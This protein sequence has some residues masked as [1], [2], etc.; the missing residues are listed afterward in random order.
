MVQ[1]AKSLKEK[2]FLV[3]NKIENS[4]GKVTRAVVRE[5]TGGSDRDVSRYIAEWRKSLVPE[6]VPENVPNHT[7]DNQALTVR[8]DGKVEASTNSRTNVDTQQSGY[9]GTPNSDLEAI[10]RRGAERAAALL[11][12][13][14]A[15]MYHLLENPDRLPED[16]RQQVEGYKAR[17][18]ERTERRQEQYNPD[19]F[20]EAAIGR[21]S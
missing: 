11:I 1:E 6:N 17:N 13:E 4:G 5:E 8:E 18:N 15:V 14:D 21:F 9:S 7:E 10:A 19:F 12:G 3:C 16:L 20:V 2:V